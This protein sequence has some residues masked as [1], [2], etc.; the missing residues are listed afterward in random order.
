VDCG[1]T[2]ATNE[3]SSLLN[4]QELTRAAASAV[5]APGD[6]YHLDE[7]RIALDPSNPAH[8]L[9]KI[10]IGEKV[11]DIGCGAGQTL[12]AACAYRQNGEGGLCTTCSRNDCPT[13]GY[14][15]DVD[16]DALALGH[17]WTKRMVLTDNR[18]E[19]LPFPDQ[20]FDVII[21]RVTLVFADLPVAAREMR[22]VLK[23]GGRLWLTVH[24]IGM[25]LKQFKN[26]KSWK[27]FLYLAYVVA[28]GF[29]FHFTLQPLSLFGRR[30]S[31]QTS[32]GMK[33]LLT[34]AGFSDV[35]TNH[36]DRCF[37]VTAKG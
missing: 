14:G 11:L 23:P 4:L 27:G 28:N 21:S 12:I 2:H 10:N 6:T 26:P 18:A 13:W 3:R 20:E 9:P 31:W 37:L 7:L 17:R 34:R 5:S 15:I 1:L 33:R 8:S 25:V 19:N 32:S 29:I 22:R 35:Q 30:E 36:T 24:P 16:K